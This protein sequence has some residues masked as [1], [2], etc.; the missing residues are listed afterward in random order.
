MTMKIDTGGAVDPGAVMPDVMRIA[1]GIVGTANALRAAAEKGDRRLAYE[2]RVQLVEQT[3][4]S[5]TI[6]AT[7]PIRTCGTCGAE[8]HPTRR[9]SWYCCDPCNARARL[10]RYRQ[11]RKAKQ[12]APAPE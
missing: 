8:F 12:Q 5:E 1:E 3:T 6:L 2:L 9:D 4:A 10:A 11:R 7:P